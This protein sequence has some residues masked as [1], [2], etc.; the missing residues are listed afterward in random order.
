MPKVKRT[1][2]RGAILDGIC[3]KIGINR[4][5]KQGSPYLN[6]RELLVLASYIDILRSEN[7]QLK[8]TNKA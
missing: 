4:R 2:N 5:A 1:T 3:S 6:R 8:Q 7:Y